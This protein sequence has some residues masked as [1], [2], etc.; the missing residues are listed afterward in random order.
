MHWAN[1]I[2]KPYDCNKEEVEAKIREEAEKEGDGLYY[3]F[4]WLDL[5]LKDLSEADKYIDKHDKT[6]RLFAVSYYDNV[7]KL[8]TATKKFQKKYENLQK[9]FAE[10]ND[11][12]HYRG[13]KSQYVS[14]PYCGS[15]LATKYISSNDCP[16]C[17]REL[18][19]EGV[20]KK[21][22]DLH[23]KMYDANVAYHES[24]QADVKLNKR[25]RGLMWLIKYEYHM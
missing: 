24:Y 4:E 1:I 11:K 8:S 19:P 16:L 5:K 18:R 9:E 2:E 25:T 21:I 17:K 14:C 12:I 22:S 10:A 20:L 7:L 13:V 15:K 6:Y 23:Q 3:S